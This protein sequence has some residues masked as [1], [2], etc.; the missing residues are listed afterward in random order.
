MAIDFYNS[1]ENRTQQVNFFYTYFLGRSADTAGQQH[2][3]GQLQAGVSEANVMQS[4]LLSPEY[5]GENDNSAFVNTMYYAILGRQAET[6]GFNYWVGQLTAGTPRST[7]AA[8]FIFSQEAID[9]VVKSMY[10][11]Y[12]D[13]PATATDLSNN[14]NFLEHGGTFG[15]VAEI[16]LGSQ[17]CYNNAANSGVP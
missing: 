8:Q 17:E 14:E 1:T 10:Q 12:L 4:F 5:T 16:L 11:S 2:W 6:N 7:A 15:Q 9:R 3:V 13:R